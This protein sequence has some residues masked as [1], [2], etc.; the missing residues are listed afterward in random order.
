MGIAFMRIWL[1]SAFISIDWWVT[2]LFTTKTLPADTASGGQIYTFVGSVGMLTLHCMQ[3]E[4][5]YVSYD[6]Q[7]W[8]NLCM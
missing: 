2:H 3:G 1:H 7:A 6:F 8:P 5:P 4:N